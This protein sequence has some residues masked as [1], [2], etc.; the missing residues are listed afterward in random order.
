MWTWVTRDLD[1]YT[2]ATELGKGA[3]EGMAWHG[4]DLV[5]YGYLGKDRGWLGEMRCVMGSR[6]VCF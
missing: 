2:G 3:G 4:Q 1:V 6:S 5:I